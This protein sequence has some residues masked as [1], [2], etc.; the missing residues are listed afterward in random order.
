DNYQNLAIELSD[1]RMKYN[2]ED[3]EILTGVNLDFSNK[4]DKLKN[5]NAELK[6]AFSQSQ[7]SVSS[8]SA[9]NNSSNSDNKRLIKHLKFDKKSKKGKNCYVTLMIRIMYHRKVSARWKNLKK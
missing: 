4:S 3:N 1:L 8:F 7:S 9:L 2:Q 5:E 6:K